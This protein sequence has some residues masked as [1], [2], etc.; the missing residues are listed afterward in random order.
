MCVDIL[1]ARGVLGDEVSNFLVTGGV[2][3]PKLDA[4]GLGVV[5]KRLTNGLSLISD[6]DEEARGLDPAGIRPE[7]NWKSEYELVDARDSR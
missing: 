7:G 1:L 3:N 2:G 5:G 4:M 6:S